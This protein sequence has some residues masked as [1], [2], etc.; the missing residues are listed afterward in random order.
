MGS[1]INEQESRVEGIPIEDEFNN[2]EK[3]EPDEE[4]TIDGNL[5]ANEKTDTVIEIARDVEDT[6]VEYFPIR[7]ELNDAEQEKSDEE[8]VT[9]EYLSADKSNNAEQEV[10]NEMDTKN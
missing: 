8:D 5:L 9:N 7:N 6:K 1:P 2:V 4:D 10:S 3:E